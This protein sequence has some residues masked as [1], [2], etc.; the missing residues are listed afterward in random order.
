M[1]EAG[2]DDV[3]IIEVPIVLPAPAD[4]FMDFFRKFSVRVSMIL[5]RQ[6]EAVKRLIET[7]IVSGLARFA[8]DEVLQIPMPAF[9]VSGRKATGLQGASHAD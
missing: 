8:G 1:E 7:E 6:D 2:F 4:T 5:E 3:Q 9:V